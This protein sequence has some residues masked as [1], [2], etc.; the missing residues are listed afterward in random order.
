MVRSLRAIPPGQMK[1]RLPAWL[2]SLRHAESVSLGE[3]E[4]GLRRA[5]DDFAVAVSQKAD[6]EKGPPIEVLYDASARFLVQI[7]AIVA[8]VTEAM[9]AALD[10]ITSEIGPGAIELRERLVREIRVEME[11][12]SQYVAGYVDGGGLVLIVLTELPP[13]LSCHTGEVAALLS[14]RLIFLPSRTEQAVESW[15]SMVQR[16]IDGWLL[17]MHGAPEPAASPERE[18]LRARKEALLA[19]AAEMKLKVTGV[20]EHPSEASLDRLQDKLLA[21]AKRKGLPLPAALVTVDRAETVPLPDP[22][23]LEAAVTL[24]KPPLKT[25][26]PPKAE[27]KEP[28]WIS[29]VSV[30]SAGQ[31][32]VWN[33]DEEGLTIGRTRSSRVHVRDDPGISRQHATIRL[34]DGCCTLFDH[35]STKGTYVDGHRIEGSVVLVGG[36]EILMSETRFRVRTKRRGRKG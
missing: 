18:A 29:L 1:G 28:G 4:L 31:E 24:H 9:S 36:E 25:K 27:E 26:T 8:S 11:R 30:D 21:V 13:D 3:V 20:P 34:V 16:D 2:G 33:I 17:V 14:E 7:R 6:P 23:A 35:G 12:L 22:S 10:A 15:I 32:S 19:A 5:V